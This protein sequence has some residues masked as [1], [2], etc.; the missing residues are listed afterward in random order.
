LG[1]L[2]SAGSLGRILGP[3]IG[4]ELFYYFG[5]DMPFLF[6]SFILFLVFLGTLK[7]RLIIK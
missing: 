4:G 6:A 1:F 2:Q 5:K 7:K 3:I